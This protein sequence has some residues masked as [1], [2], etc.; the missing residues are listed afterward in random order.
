VKHYEIAAIE[1]DRIGR[2]VIPEDLRVLEAAG[3][4]FDLHFSWTNFNWSCE[5]YKETGRL[6]PAEGL[7]PVELI[8][9]PL[10]RCSRLRGVPARNL[11]LVVLF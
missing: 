9:R 2:E 6:M 10:S 3:R 11:A 8:R 4:R 7:G 5:T 1:G